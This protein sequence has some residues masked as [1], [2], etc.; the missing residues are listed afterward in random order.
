MPDLAALADPDYRPP[1]GPP[2]SVRHALDSADADTADLL[3]KAL[4]NPYAG[5]TSIR[6]ALTERGLNVPITAIRRHRRRECRCE[7]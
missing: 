5:S 1:K 6:D 4:A 3:T 2:C 7:P